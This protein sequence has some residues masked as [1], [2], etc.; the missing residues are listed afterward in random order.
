MEVINNKVQVKEKLGH[1]VQI[2]LPFAVKNVTLCLSLH[3]Y[4]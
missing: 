1:V 4:L 2:H 3:C